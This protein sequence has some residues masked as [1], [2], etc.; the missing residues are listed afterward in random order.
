MGERSV[1]RVAVELDGMCAEDVAEGEE[2]NDEERRLRGP[3]FD[4]CGDR[5]RISVLASCAA[6]NFQSYVKFSAHQ[7]LSG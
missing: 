4:P 1:I 3:R 6:V 5:D 2:L 7:R